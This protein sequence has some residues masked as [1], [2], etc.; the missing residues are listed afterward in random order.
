MSKADHK[1]KIKDVRDRLKKLAVKP[2]GFDQ[3]RMADRADAAN[4]L[5]HDAFKLYGRAN[6]KDN[7]QENCNQLSFKRKF[8][9]FCCTKTKALEEERSGCLILCKEEIARKRAVHAGVC[10]SAVGASAI[11]QVSRATSELPGLQ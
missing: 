1:E 3:G 8:R 4:T 11:D 7:W 5:L 2:S 10:I 9:N 6:G